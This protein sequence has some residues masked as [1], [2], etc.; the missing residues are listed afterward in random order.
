MSGV[1]G[2]PARVKVSLPL[3]KAENILGD[4]KRAVASHQAGDGIF[5][6]ALHD[7]GDEVEG[8]IREAKAE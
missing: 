2:V 4:I 5:P 3:W 7:F 8:A 6:L 1:K